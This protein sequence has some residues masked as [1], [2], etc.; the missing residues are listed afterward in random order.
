M[1]KIKWANYSGL[2]AGTIFLMH[3]QLY[4]AWRVRLYQ[5]GPTNQGSWVKSMK[6]I[7]NSAIEGEDIFV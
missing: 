5:G 7:D 4:R 6:V 1:T 2:L 3:G